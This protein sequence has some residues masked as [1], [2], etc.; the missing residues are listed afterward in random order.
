MHDYAEF[1]DAQLELNGDRLGTDCLSDHALQ[2]NV[3]LVLVI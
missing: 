2:E 1:G 3:K